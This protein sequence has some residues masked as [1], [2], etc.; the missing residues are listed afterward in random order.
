VLKIHYLQHV[1][2]ETPGYLDTLTAAH[3]CSISTTRLWEQ[4][5]FP[6]PSEI[7]LLV[8]L[9]GPMNIYGYERYPW[10]TDEKRFLEKIIESDTKML[11]ICL[12]S[13]LLADV[14][15]GSVI[16]NRCK[17]IGWF[18]V[19]LSREAGVSSLF[20]HFPEQ[21]TPFHWHG[22]TY[23][24]PPGAIRLGSSEACEN[25]GFIFKNRIA[26][27]QFHLEMVPH[28]LQSLIDNCGNELAADEYIQSADE[29]GEKYIMFMEQSHQLMTQ[30]FLNLVAT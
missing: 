15:G 12:G 10:L 25:Q 29:I 18:P 3:G 2:F 16:K 17:E 9:G 14:L 21:F 20:K 4:T 30:L 7:D 6:S 24:L 26:A 28:N 11:G 22:D 23:R 27:L 1:P 5:V 13:Q 19:S 8:I